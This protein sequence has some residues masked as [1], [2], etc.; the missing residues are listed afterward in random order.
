MAAPYRRLNITVDVR[1]ATD[2]N[3]TNVTITMTPQASFSSLRAEL[4]RHLKYP[5]KLL[6]F[7]VGERHIW[8]EEYDHTPI[9]QCDLTKETLIC[10]MC[11]K[12]DIRLVKYDPKKVVFLMGF[13]KRV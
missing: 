13:H 9:F 7:M 2:A 8:K 12:G 11:E 10:I 3:V 6:K 5:P 4:A 1:S